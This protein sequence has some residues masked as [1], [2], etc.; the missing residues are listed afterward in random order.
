MLISFPFPVFALWKTCKRFGI[1]FFILL[2]SF[3]LGTSKI[4]LIAKI[5]NKHGLDN[6]DG[7]LKIA[8]AIVIDRGYLGAEVDYE[9]V[10]TA[11][12]E[13]I[14]LSNSVGK[15]VWVA[16]QVLESMKGHPRPTRS[17]A[18]DVTNAVMDGCDG[19]VL[20]SETAVGKYVVESVKVMSKVILAAEKRTDYQEFQLKQMRNAPKPIGVSESIASSAVACARQVGATVIIC[21]TEYGGTARLVA[22]YRPQVPVLATTHIQKTAKQL[23]MCFGVFPYYYHGNPVILFNDSFLKEAIVTATM[24]NHFLL[25]CLENAIELGLCKP[26]DVAVITSGQNI[27]FADGTTTKMQMRQIPAL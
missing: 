1:V 17:E 6:F 5:E 18:A 12:K 20:S 27:G 22:K 7:I 13:M 11:Q 3:M 16:N 24:S 9:Q 14:A 8:D 10:P 4:R 21:I 19:L 23:N 26:G 2:A 15:P 25:I